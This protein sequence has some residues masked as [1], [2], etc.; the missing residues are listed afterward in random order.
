M[1]DGID[2]LEGTAKFDMLDLGVMRGGNV[3]VRLSGAR[4]AVVESIGFRQGSQNRERSERRVTARAK[5]LPTDV[6]RGAFDVSL[7]STLFSQYIY[8]LSRARPFAS[9]S[10]HW[11]GLAH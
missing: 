9:F 1:K 4:V 3:E 5:N 2:L 8:L 7:I 11:A 10:E 6:D